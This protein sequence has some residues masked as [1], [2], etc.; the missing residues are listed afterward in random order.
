MLQIADKLSSLSSISVS[1]IQKFASIILEIAE[2][3]SLIDDEMIFPE[4][5]IEEI[6]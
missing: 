5:A 4:K 3:P 1:D 2:N 6:C